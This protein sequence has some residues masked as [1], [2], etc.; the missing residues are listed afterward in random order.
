MKYHGVVC[1]FYLINNTICSSFSKFSES[2]LFLHLSNTCDGSSRATLR[3]YPKPTSPT[4]SRTFLHQFSMTS[5][6]LSSPTFYWVF[7]SGSKHPFLFISLENTFHFPHQ[8]PPHIS[9]PRYSKTPP[10]VACIDSSS[11]SP[12]SSLKPSA[13]S[14]V[15]GDCVTIS[16]KALITVTISSACQSPAVTLSLTCTL[17]AA[18]QRSL[19]PAVSRTPE[20]PGPFLSQGCSFLVSFTSSS[21]LSSPEK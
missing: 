9:F 19:L 17:S 10:R 15:D 1:I 5:S 3:W 21:C 11:F 12:L 6:M 16:P 8:L 4:H 7:S 14:P 18:A 20:F 13:L 2:R